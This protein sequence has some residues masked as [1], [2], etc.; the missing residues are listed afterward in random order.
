MCIKNVYK[1]YKSAKTL[2]CVFLAA[3]FISVDVNYSFGDSFDP[4]FNSI[5]TI[6]IGVFTNFDRD[7]DVEFKNIF[8]KILQFRN[9]TS[10]VTVIPWEKDREIARDNDAFLR[11]IFSIRMECT[12]NKSL[13]AFAIFPSSYWAGG[14]MRPSPCRDLII[15]GSISDRQQKIE[16]AKHVMELAE[17]CLLRG[18]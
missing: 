18:F 7:H 8:Y 15:A 5:T 1:K 17:N 12:P 13:C 11:M 3:F 4:R 9:T 10:G 14:D 16:L 2:F 6:E